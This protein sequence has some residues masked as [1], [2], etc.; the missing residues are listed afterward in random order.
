M[1]ARALLLLLLSV[2]ACGK[3]PPTDARR[4]LSS[5]VAAVVNGQAIGRELLL[6]HARSTR[7]T[8]RA[9]LAQLVRERLLAE[10][11]AARGY[12]RLPAV[13]IGVDQ[14]R[15]RA[16]LRLEVEREVPASDIAGR[17]RR[18]DALLDAL[19]PRTPVRFDAQGV[20]RAL[21]VASP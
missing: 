16:L 11:A 13:R 2:A 8:P 3:A 20:A 5:D 18:L 4:P 12:D 19:R 7:Q 15:V 10:Y 17:A 1:R 14:A 21:A 9:A 6:A